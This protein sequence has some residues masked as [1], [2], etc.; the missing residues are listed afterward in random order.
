M[1]VNISARHFAHD[2]LVE[3]VANALKTAGLDP[4]SLVL[5]ITESVLS[6]GRRFRDC[7]DAGAETARRGV[8]H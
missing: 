6:S 2:G 7:P 4:G 3:D 8:R 1:S 5:E